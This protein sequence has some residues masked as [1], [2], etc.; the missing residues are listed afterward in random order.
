MADMNYYNDDGNKS[1]TDFFNTKDWT[2]DFH[3]QDIEYNKGMSVMAY[4]GI[5]VLIPLIMARDSRFARF[6]VNQGLLLA[7]LETA[8]AVISSV[9]GWFPVAGLIIRI[10]CWI[11]SAVCF[12]FAIIGIVNAVNGRAKELPFIGGIRLLK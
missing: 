9:F 5:L 2:Y 6:H 11:I 4:L 3:P 8:C 12:I 7:I 10:A 1:P